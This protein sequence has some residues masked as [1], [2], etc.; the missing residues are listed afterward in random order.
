MLL[1][2]EKKCHQVLKRFLMW[3]A[4]SIPHAATEP[5]LYKQIIFSSRPNYWFYIK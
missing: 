1:V 4:Y 5:N 3:E 2:K